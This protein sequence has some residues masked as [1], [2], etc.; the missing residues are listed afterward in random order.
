[1]LDVIYNE[2]RF[3]YNCENTQIIYDLRRPCQIEGLLLLHL[4]SI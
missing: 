4:G 3:E 1:M 2:F